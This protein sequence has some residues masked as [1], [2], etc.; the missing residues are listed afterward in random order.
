MDMTE[1]INAELLF[2]I[3]FLNILG[4]WMKN[5]TVLPNKYIPLVL[6][7]VSIILC[8]CFLRTAMGK[9]I[10]DSILG[11]VIQGIFIAATA[12]YAN[13][14]TKTISEEDK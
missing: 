3:P 8:I 14:L 1:Y 11:G 6:G 10:E 7:G 2:L 5:K 13:Q 9:C 12:V 4:W